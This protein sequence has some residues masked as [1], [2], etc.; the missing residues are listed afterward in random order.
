MALRSDIY[1]GAILECLRNQLVD[2]SGDVL[3]LDEVST[4]AEIDTPPELEGRVALATLR[5]VVTQE[6]LVPTVKKRKE[7][8]CH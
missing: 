1:T 3:K 2:G 7:L 5:V 6:V 4:Y 8:S